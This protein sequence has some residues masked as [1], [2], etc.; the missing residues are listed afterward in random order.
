MKLDEKMV[1]QMFVDGGVDPKI[2]DSL[3]SDDSLLDA[4]VDSLDFA[5]LLLVIEER[6]GIKIPDEEALALDSLRSIVEYVNGKLD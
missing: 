1:V 4:G 6:F 3:P 2:L 5:N